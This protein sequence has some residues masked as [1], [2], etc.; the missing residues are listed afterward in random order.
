MRHI[1]LQDDLYDRLT[2]ERDKLAAV[3]GSATYGDVVTAGLDG[4]EDALAKGAAA[5]DAMQDATAHAVVALAK[6]MAVPTVLERRRIEGVLT[7]DAAWGQLPPMLRRGLIGD[8]MRQCSAT[9]ANRIIEDLDTWAAITERAYYIGHALNIEGDRDDQW[10]APVYDVEGNPPRTRH[11]SQHQDRPAL[12]RRE[13][14]P[15]QPTED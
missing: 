9:D 11:E 2:A 4:I 13:E 7:P 1:K 14:P 5:V 3:Q 15:D 8:A 12:R 10:S 6:A